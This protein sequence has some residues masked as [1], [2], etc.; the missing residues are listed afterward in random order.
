MTE[1]IPDAVASVTVP[2]SPARVWA[3]L[4]DPAEI[5]QYFLGT[6]VETDWQVGSPI[7]FRGEWQGKQYRDHGEVL[8][9]EPERTWRITHYS[10]LTGLPDVPE[11][12]H[13]L[14]YTIESVAD[15]TSVTIRQ[16]RNR[17]EDEVQHSE[18]LWGM[19]LDNLEKYLAQHN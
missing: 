18:Q 3:A 1:S 11:N 15:G 13:T 8:E 6:R 2:H 14:S 17:S 7:V 10:P 19:V 12:Y 9:F 16:G 5:A 4:T